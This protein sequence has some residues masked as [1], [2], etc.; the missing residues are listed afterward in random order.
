MKDKP[1][2]VIADKL[3]KEFEE[4]WTKSFENIDATPVTI[5]QEDDSDL[6]SA[7]KGC[8]AIITEKQE[9][10]RE[11]LTQAGQNLKLVLKLSDWLTNID[12]ESCDELGIRVETVPQLGSISVAEHA[13]TLMLTCLRDVIPSHL[14]VKDGG[15]REQGLTPEET[16]E[17]S[18]AF[19]W[20]PVE[21]VEVYEKTLGI[22]GLGEIGKEVSQRAR[23][24]G[25]KV[26][27][28]DPNRLPDQWEDKLGVEY[29]SFEGLLKNS[30]VIT[31]H[32]PHTEQTEN[33]IGK[34]ELATMKS[35]AYLINTCRGGVVDESALVESLKNEDIGGAGLDVFEKE[36]L[37]A[38]S[39]LTDLENVVLTCHIGGGSG[40]GWNDLMN[41]IEDNIENHLR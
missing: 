5:S 4:R 34:E 22:V 30:D 28:S 18:F 26:L 10:D 16:T 29:S 31:L 36:P 8:D 37:P 13:I 15:Y 17:R 23:S 25:M 39:P 32:V 9:I 20:L 38:D 14:G 12:R 11:V 2:V 1:V 40:T 19:K 35:S 3:T 24:L 33:L 6:L 7:V 21:P 27:Y 41:K